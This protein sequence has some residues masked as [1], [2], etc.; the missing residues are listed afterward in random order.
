MVPM[1]PGA[2]P[3]LLLTGL[4][5]A[6]A[7]GVSCS[8]LLRERAPPPPPPPVAAAPVTPPAPMG[9]HVNAEHPI[10]A[11]RP[12]R[13]GFAWI[14]NGPQADEVHLWADGADTTLAQAER[15]GELHTSGDQV[16]WVEDSRIL[17]GY[18]GGQVRTLWTHEG[19]IIYSIVPDGAGGVVAVA[20][21]D[22]SPMGAWQV[23]ADGGVTPLPAPPGLILLV[24][25]DGA[26][27]WAAQR[28]DKPGLYRLDRGRDAWERLAD[29]SY[30]YPVARDGRVY[31]WERVGT[32]DNPH[33]YP[34]RQC[35]RA[36][37]GTDR[38]EH[39]VQDRADGTLPAIGGVREVIT[40]DDRGV[41]WIADDGAVLGRFVVPNPGPEWW[42]ERV[43]GG[44]FWW[45]YTGLGVE[46]MSTP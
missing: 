42:Y 6:L 26:G 11:A 2:I 10:D 41:E 32:R 8:A 28:G 43:P 34:D 12:T 18:A 16:F 23:G 4:L 17:R 3:A 13:S 19:G 20:Q 1:R 15:V 24:Y 37:D 14:E 33:M 46:P 45:T 29:I 9:P 39:R 44:V 22:G 21:A 38:R 36:V 7:A 30:Y 5:L 40:A 31:W 25:A 35:S 27:V